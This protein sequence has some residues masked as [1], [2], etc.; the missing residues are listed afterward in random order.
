MELK[1]L[2]RNIEVVKFFGVKDRI[3]NDV[4]NNS[5]EIKLND[6]FIA[7]DGNTIDGHI[8]I[9]DAIQNGSKSIVCQTIP[10]EIRN[11]ITYVVVNNTRKVYSKICSNYFKNPS[12]KMYLIGKN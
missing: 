7:I 1:E 3:I 10:E 9:N 12:K 8:F 6:L 5:R 4:K 2:L 11:D